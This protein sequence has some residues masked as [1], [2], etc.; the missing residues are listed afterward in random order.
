MG[1]TVKKTISRETLENIFVTAIEGGSNYWYEIPDSEVDKIK[2]A[3]GKSKG[4]GK[5]FS[6][7]LFEAVFDKGIDIDVHDY[8]G[9]E[10]RLGTL[11]M[12]T[13]PDRLQALIDSPHNWALQRE[14]DEEG[15]AQTSDVV[16]QYLVM[17]DIVFG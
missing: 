13:L 15:D 11:S 12:S 17:E 4:D 14:I 5:S 10:W 1:I 2:K 7:S 6:E 16:F 3:V 8:E 9:P